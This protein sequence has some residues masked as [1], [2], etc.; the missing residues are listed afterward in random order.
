DGFVARMSTDLKSLGWGSYIGGTGAEVV[1]GIA[2]DITG[3]V[4]VTGQAASGFP[5]SSPFQSTGYGGNSDAFV[6][7]VPPGGGSVSWASYLGGSGTDDGTAIAVDD[8]GAVYLTGS[9]TGSFPA[10]N[11]YGG[12][13]TDAY[14]V[15]VNAAGSSK[16]YA[17][18]IGGTTAEIGKG[19]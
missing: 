8:T 12:G 2:S 6:A 11:S 16:T 1:R 13:G 15:K 5:T 7:Q 4:Y 18:Y 3:N 10:T 19:I 14:L 17:K 9:S